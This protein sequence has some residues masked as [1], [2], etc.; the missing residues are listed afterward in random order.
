MK[1]DNQQ[2]GSVR[3]PDAVAVEAQH[4]RDRHLDAVR[5][6]EFTRDRVGAPG[7]DVRLRAEH[8]IAVVND[9]HRYRS[10][11]CQVASMGASEPEASRVAIAALKVADG[12]D[13]EFRR[14]VERFK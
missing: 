4:W 8:L 14:F 6:L 9:W 1:S 13:S 10:T 12:D 5:D 11:L 7:S 2:A 3:D